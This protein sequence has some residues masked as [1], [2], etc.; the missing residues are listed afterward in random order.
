MTQRLNQSNRL[1]FVQLIAIILHSH[2]PGYQSSA[3][4]C[5]SKQCVLDP[6]P[7]WLVKSLSNVFTPVLTSVMLTAVLIDAADC[8]GGI[9]CLLTLA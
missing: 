7:T 2:S 9:Y 8:V 1:S 4:C 5:P 6:V 3:R